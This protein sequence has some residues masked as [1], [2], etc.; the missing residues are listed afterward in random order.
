MFLMHSA[1]SIKALCASHPTPAEERLDVHK[2]LGGDTTDQ[3]DIPRIRHH[4]PAY[5]AGRRICSE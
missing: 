4:A 2:D 3:R 5:R 1:C